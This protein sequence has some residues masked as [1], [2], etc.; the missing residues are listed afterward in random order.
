MHDGIHTDAD[1][2]DLA[3]ILVIAKAVAHIFRGLQRQ[4][5]IEDDDVMPCLGKLGDNV[6]ANPPHTTRDQ[7]FHQQLT[8]T[9]N[10]A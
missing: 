5:L 6:A 9:G 1:L 2:G 4:G 8:F 3:K 10:C 7:Y